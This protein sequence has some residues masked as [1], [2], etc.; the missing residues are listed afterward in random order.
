M[1]GRSGSSVGLTH[2]GVVESSHVSKRAELLTHA[3]TA[4]G[5]FNR[6]VVSSPTLPLRQSIRWAV[7]SAGSVVSAFHGDH[8][9]TR[10]DLTHSGFSNAGRSHL[11]FSQ[12]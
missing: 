3:Q 4:A 5:W 2:R 12:L 7:A 9:E 1:A 11:T 6:F 10:F 8:W